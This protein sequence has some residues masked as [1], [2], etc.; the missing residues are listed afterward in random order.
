MKPPKAQLLPPREYTGEYPVSNPTQH[1]PD[2]L[3]EKEATSSS[4]PKPSSSITAAGSCRP[5]I[6]RCTTATARSVRDPANSRPKA[7]LPS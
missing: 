3:T 5:R 6:A 7:S 1:P 2:M 4:C